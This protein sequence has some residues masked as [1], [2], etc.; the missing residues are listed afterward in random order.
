MG[1]V[2]THT[3]AFTYVYVDVNV[4]SCSHFFFLSFN[5]FDTFNYTLNAF[6]FC[7]L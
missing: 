3:L 7:F 2:H 1:C 5:L 6:L 4:F